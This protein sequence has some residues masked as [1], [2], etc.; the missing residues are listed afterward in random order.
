[1]GKAMILPQASTPRF[2][3]AVRE[4]SKPSLHL[5]CPGG[6]TTVRRVWIQND[7]GRCLMASAFV[8]YNGM[9]Y[10]SRYCELMDLF[11]YTRRMVSAK[12]SAMLM[13]C[14]LSHCLV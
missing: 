7:E 5:P 13:M 14:T 4:Y 1:M 2:P 10:Y 11:S 6:H 3:S 12:R 8:C 9:L